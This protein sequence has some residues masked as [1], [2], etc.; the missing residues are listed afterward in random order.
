MG[1]NG[2]SM[3]PLIE[4]AAKH[5]LT[6]RPTWRFPSEGIELS[7]EELY[8]L[9]LQY[10]HKLDSLGI[11]YQDKVG[12]ILDNS[13]DYVALIIALLKLNTIIVPLRPKWNKHTKCDTYLT[14]CD[15]VC[16]FKLILYEDTGVVSAFG[17][18]TDVA[19]KRALSLDA[20]K[21]IPAHPDFSYSPQTHSHDIAILQ[22]SSGSTGQPKAVIVTHGMVMAQLVNL[23]ENHTRSRRGLPVSSSASWMPIHHDMGLFIGV[24]K[25]LF[26]GCDNLL[27]PPSYYMRNPGRW[28]LHLSTHRVDFT[29]TTNSALATT[30]NLIARKIQGTDVSLDA[31][32]IYIAAE[33]V[34]PLMVRRCYEVLPQLRMPMDQLHIGYGMAENALGCSCTRTPTIS[35]IR[36]LIRDNGHVL[37][38]TADDSHSDVIELVSIGT[39][40]H[41]HE[42]TVRDEH[43]RILPELQLGEIHVAGPCVSPGYFNNDAATR[44]AFVDGRFRSG[45]LGF[46][47]GS[48]LYFYGRR[49]DMITVGGRNIV[50]DDIEGLAEELPFIRP[51]TTCLTAVENASAGTTELVLL[52]EMS[53]LTAVET[54]RSYATTVQRHI[55]SEL[56]VLLTRVL[57]CPK[58][59]IEKTSSGKKRRKV[60]RTR[61]MNNQLEA[62]G[63]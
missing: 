46:Y 26:V 5:A 14:K 53:P 19:N 24:L 49:D 6:R 1:A 41:R 55:Y 50:P 9:S 31:L 54:L 52:V 34:S 56:E 15:S 13:S 51:T 20:F 58:G 37:P 38:L 39:P 17:S 33:K 28:F 32:H 36:C 22:F 60:I 30:L 44:R 40:D 2:V 45:D 21:L 61:L 18:W 4:I 43:D 27:A 3:E 42:I 29:F 62:I 7:L 10:A 63:M 11:G 23:V 25:P 8:R 47:Y 48:E 16:N 12:L 57:F 35:I 59:T